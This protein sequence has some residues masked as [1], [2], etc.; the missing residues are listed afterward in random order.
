MKR[1]TVL[2]TVLVIVMAMAGILPVFATGS[3]EGEKFIN[4]YSSGSDNVRI[5]W[6]AVIEAFHKTNPGFTVK[7]QYVASGTGGQTSELKVIAAW[8]AKQKEIDVD[9][10]A[11]I[12]ENE[13]ARVQKEASLEALFKLDPKKI[14]NWANVAARSVI[15]PDRTM[16]FRGT[17]VFIAYNSDKVPTPPKTEKEL[18]AWIKANPGK[19]AYNDPGTGGAGSSFVTTTIYNLMPVEALTSADEKW[20]AQWDAGLAVLKD[21]H[22]FL[23]KASGKVQYTVKNQGSLDLLADGT[24]W[25]CPAWADMTLDQKSRKLLPA[26]IKLTNIEPSLTGNLTMVAIPSASTKAA[27][28]QKFLNYIAS[29][30]AQDIFVRVMK[31][32]PVIDTAKL[33][34]AT[35]ELLSG[36]KVTTKYRTSTLGALGTKLNARWTQDIATLP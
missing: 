11:D 35:I 28:S 20:M 36:L 30:E 7:Q 32:I 4:L 22:P 25:M 33:P 1:R 19:F 17:A 24:I 26:S 21:L 6:E 3:G 27:L 31:A 29:A 8:Q 18:H 10:M 14:P 16:A 9:I 23:Y 13:V 34:P 15:A 12:G 5:V 2:C